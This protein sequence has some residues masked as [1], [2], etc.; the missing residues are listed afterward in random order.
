M[1]SPLLLVLSN[2]DPV[3][4]TAVTQEEFYKSYAIPD[5]LGGIQGNNCT[6]MVEQY[7]D[8]SAVEQHK[9]IITHG[10]KVGYA[11][12][13]HTTFDYISISSPPIFKDYERN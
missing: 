10:I 12:D 4:V 13:E 8:W 3:T 1:D 6:I 5:L 9:L 7:G 2:I 11:I